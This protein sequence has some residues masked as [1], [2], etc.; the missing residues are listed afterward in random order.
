LGTSDKALID[1][2]FYSDKAP[3]MAAAAFPGFAAAWFLTK[4]THFEERERLFLASWVACATSS[5]L[6]VA[7]GSV[8]F[9]DLLS[10]FVSARAALV[11]AVTI[12]FGAAPLPYATVMFSHSLVVGLLLMS[13]WVIF[14]V[15]PGNEQFQRSNS[16]WCLVAG[17][18]LGWALASEY[19]I[20]LIVIGLGVYIL[21]ILDRTNLKMVLAGFIPP[22]LMIPLYSWSTVGNPFALPYSYQ[23][24]FPAMREGLFAIKWP[25]PVTAFHLLC[26]S[27]RGFFFW[28]PFMAMVFFGYSGLA[29]YSRKLF[30]LTLIV[31]ALHVIVLSG[32]EWDWP[33]G[34]TLGPRF[35]VCLLPLLAIPCAF[36]LQRFPIAGLTLAI[37]SIVINTLATVTD[38][39]PE[40][41]GH[42]NP[43]FDLHI[44][45]FL[46]GD[47]SPNIGM[48][49]G[50]SP[51]M[52]ILVFYGILFGGICWISR[53]LGEC[54]LAV[55][56]E[57]ESAAIEKRTNGIPI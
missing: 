36:G 34:P 39:C 30:W 16:R 3:G 10:Q 7:I 15:V 41:S 53:Q 25:N 31:P 52:S 48:K 35:L 43:L 55:V 56:A 49:L 23:A 54:N 42:P 11:T 50:L 51:Y 8:L 29:R 38:A 6:A 18:C 19:T 33:A 2:R 22:L 37:Y 13:L 32:R 17:Y 9:F 14:K 20:G 21:A 47:F 46:R 12:V 4:P 45:L 28:M 26:G 5:G 27:S 24:S 1:G 44:P 57:E 40:F